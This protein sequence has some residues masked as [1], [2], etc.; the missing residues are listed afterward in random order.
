M[1]GVGEGGGVLKVGVAMVGN[2]GHEERVRGQK[3]DEKVF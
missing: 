1:I 2:D 3:N